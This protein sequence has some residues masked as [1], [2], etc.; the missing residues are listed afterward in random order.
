MHRILTMM[1]SLAVAGGAAAPAHAQDD[2]RVAQAIELFGA[3]E[4]VE[5]AELFEA[6]DR[7]A[8]ANYLRLN[9]MVAWYKADRCEKATQAMGRVD[10]TQPLEPVDLEDIDRVR[11][12]CQ[13]KTARQHEAAGRY[14]EALA[15]LTG[16]ETLDDELRA[17]IA[18]VRIEVAKK[19]RRAAERDSEGEVEPPPEPLSGPTVT[20]KPAWALWSGLGLGGGGVLLGTATL[21][22]HLAFDVPDRRAGNDSFASALGCGGGVYDACSEAEKQ[23]IAEHP[24]WDGWRDQLR[25]ASTQNVVLGVSA[26]VLGAG[27]AALLIYYA[28]AGGGDE[29]SAS[30]ILAPTLSP[31]GAGAVLE[32]RF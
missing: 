4:F 26:G 3:E 2:P 20:P 30:I 10:R 15:I 28:L 23:R 21:V 29:A 12:Y 7:D 27:G 9:A 11:A 16:L 13:L 1:L 25:S 31:A 17:Q 18:A 6:A 32:L 8:P 14:D 19:K 5:A 24:D 22:K